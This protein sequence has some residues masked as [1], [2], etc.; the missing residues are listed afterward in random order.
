MTALWIL[1]ALYAVNTLLTWLYLEPRRRALRAWAFE[2]TKQEYHKDSDREWNEE[3]LRIERDRLAAEVERLRA[4]PESQVNLCQVDPE[5][6]PE[7]REALG[8]VV[9]AAERMATEISRQPRPSTC[10]ECNA[11]IADHG[12]TGICPTTQDDEGR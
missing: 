12:A 3:A 6:S 2:Q 7:S 5:M 1:A 10:V 11:S 4:R 9:K 8:E